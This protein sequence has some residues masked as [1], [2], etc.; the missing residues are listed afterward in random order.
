MV[1]VR[2]IAVFIIMFYFYSPSAYGLR[3]FSVH[4]S[5]DKGSV[6]SDKDYVT[7]ELL[8]ESKNIKDRKEVI[9]KEV[10]TLRR[11]REKRLKPFVAEAKNPY[12][13]SF[14]GEDYDKE[15][16]YMPAKREEKTGD[17]LTDSSPVPTD[18]KPGILFNLTFLFL[19]G[20]SFFAARVFIRPK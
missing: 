17:I 4:D 15:P 7:V 19:L 16:R 18:K 10:E 3:Y 12:P 1:G 11:E 5:E 14:S 6:F 8:E 2:F 13:G 9:S 20:A